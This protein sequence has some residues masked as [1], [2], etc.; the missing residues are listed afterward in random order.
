MVPRPVAGTPGSPSA[1]AGG[2]EQRARLVASIAARLGSERE[3]TWIVEHVEHVEH[4]D[5]HRSGRAPAEGLIGVIAPGQGDLRGSDANRMWREAEALAERRASGE[6]LQYV[7][8]RWP[9]RTLDLYV[10]PRVL[11]PRPETEHVVGVALAELERVRTASSPRQAASAGCTCVDL[12]TGSG[13]IALSLAVEA[14]SDEH[15][16]VDV[17][18]TDESADALMVARTNLDALAHLNPAAAA[19]VRLVE[20]SWFDALPPDLAGRVGLLVSNPPYVSESEYPELEP[21]VREWEP[22]SALV[23]KDGACGAGGMAAIEEIID[24]AQRWL[25]QSGAVVIEIAPDQADVAVEAVRRAGFGDVGVERDLTG[26]L[27]VLVA[28]C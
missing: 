16:E 20:G 18:A 27:R 24:G 13:A 3:A 1:R 10:D 28:R 9:F 2:D 12:G 15:M 22:R 5:A 19:R 8:G 14:D 17:W 6:P 26:R 23:A 21:T 4:V 25:R 7:L 11:V